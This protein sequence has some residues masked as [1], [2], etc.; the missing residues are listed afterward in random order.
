MHNTNIPNTILKYIANYTKGR[1]QYTL[2]NN[3]KS[4]LRNTKTGVP[5][6]GVLSPTLFNIYTADLPTPTSPNITTVTYADDTTILSTHTNPHIA[7]QQVQPYLNEIYDWTKQNQL[8]LKL[9]KTTTTLFT[10]DPA[11]YNTTLTLQINNTTLPT[12]KEPKI[13]GLTLDPKLTYSKH[14][15]NTTL[16]AKQTIHIMK[17]LTTTHWG[18]SKETLNITYK[19]IIRPILEYASAIWSPIISNTN[20]NKLQTIHNSA[21]RTITGCTLDTNTH[22]LHTETKVLPIDTHMKLHGSQ[23]RQQ[24]QDHTLH[25]LTTQE[26][27]PRLIKQTIFHNNNYT[28]NIEKP[29]DTTTQ[30]TI[31]ANTAQIHTQIVS[32]HMQAIPHNKMLNTT[33]PEISKTEQALPHYTRRLL[34]QLR[35]NKSPILHEYLHKITPETHQT[36]PYAT[37]NHTTPNT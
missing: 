34:A 21:L 7:Q 8:T 9:P 29:P 28:T 37:N 26:P 1:K 27:P 14:I 16:K 22:H 18:E 23:L 31:R 13:L 6:G 17:T 36:V 35:T 15:Q 2:Y 19:A 5:Q 32:N 3:Y 11:E 12:N 33:A 4:T 25:Q 30:E 10:P 20:M 24:A